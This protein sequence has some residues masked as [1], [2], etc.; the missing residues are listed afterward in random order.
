[1]KEKGG[2]NYVPL[3]DILPMFP[4]GPPESSVLNKPDETVVFL[5]RETGA[6]PQVEAVRQPT[7]RSAY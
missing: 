6:E 5:G 1:M 7:T 4:S 3:L 2:G